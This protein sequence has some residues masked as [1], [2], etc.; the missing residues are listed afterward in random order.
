[1]GGG[2]EEG[3]GRGG[4]VRQSVG[5]QTSTMGVRRRTGW[6]RQRGRR[7]EVAVTLNYEGEVNQRRSKVGVGCQPHAPPTCRGNARSVGALR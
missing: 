4:V 1:M 7:G 2:T 3:N 6:E 5:D